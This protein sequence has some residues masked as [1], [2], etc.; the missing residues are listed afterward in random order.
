MHLSHDL[1]NSLSRLGVARLRR[2]NAPHNAIGHCFDIHAR[3]YKFGCQVA[4]SGSIE[5]DL[6]MLGYGRA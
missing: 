5:V 1:S 3:K 4:C 6:L 2:Q